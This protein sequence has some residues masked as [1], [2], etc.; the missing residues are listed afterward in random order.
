[1]RRIAFS[2]I[3]LCVAAGLAITL[4]LMV[5]LDA[6]VEREIEREGARVLGAPV[7]VGSVDLRI[8]EGTGRIRDLRVGNPKGFAGDEAIAFDE[9]FLEVVPGS[10]VEPPLRLAQVVVD[11]AEVHLEV[12]AQGRSNL[13]RIAAHARETPAKDG[14]SSA[15]GEPTRIVIDELRFAGG[16]VLLDRPGADTARADLPGF[17]RSDIGGSAGATGG[18]IVKVV[19]AALTRQVAATAAGNEVRRAVERELGGTA[20]EAAGSLVRGLLGD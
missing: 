20:G 13:D 10:I 11:R 6:I 3:A 1:M 7:H 17:E 19:A 16:S 8:S 9:I 12:D 2:A 4:Y 5:S 15:K 18:E 14:E